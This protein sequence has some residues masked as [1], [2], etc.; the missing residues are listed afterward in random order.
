M[1]FDQVHR[2]HEDDPSWS[3]RL[4][5]QLVADLESRLAQ[6]IDR[7]GRLVLAANA[8]VP[9]APMLYLAHKK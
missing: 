2:P 3:R 5:D 9:A 4:D 1:L 8:S 7:Q 6:R